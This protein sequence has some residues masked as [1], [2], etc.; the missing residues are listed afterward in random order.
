[1]EVWAQ[2]GLLALL[3][4][5]ALPGVRVQTG[6]LAPPVRLS[7]MAL[8]APRVR[9]APLEVRAQLALVARLVRLGAPDWT[10]RL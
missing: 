8:V 10:A 7:Q 5:R 2:M 3:V 4:Q 1:M 6:L 9:R